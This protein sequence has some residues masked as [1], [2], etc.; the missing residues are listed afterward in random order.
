LEL[1][2]GRRN[3]KENR[4]LVARR[5]DLE[6]AASGFFDSPNSIDVLIL[7]VLGGVKVQTLLLD[8]TSDYDTIS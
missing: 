8:K 3:E 1:L 5:Q 6:V 2:M 7:Q 4:E